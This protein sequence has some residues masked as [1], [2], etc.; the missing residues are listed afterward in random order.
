MKNKL[1]QKEIKEIEALRNWRRN[2]LA[3]TSK[4]VREKNSIRFDYLLEKSKK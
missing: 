1:T 4:E 3:D 2:P